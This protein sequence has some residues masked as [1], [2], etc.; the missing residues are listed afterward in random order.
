MAYFEGEENGV[1]PTTYT[2][3][4]ALCWQRDAC[5]NAM[6]SH[7]NLFQSLAHVNSDFP[8]LPPTQPDQLA[9]VGVVESLLTKLVCDAPPQHKHLRATEGIFSPVCASSALTLRIK[10]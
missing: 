4:R 7:P 10:V 2:Q 5:G 3:M 8:P 6:R 1:S 9:W